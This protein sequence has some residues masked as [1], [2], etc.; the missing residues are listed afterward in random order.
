[1]HEIYSLRL[2]HFSPNVCY[3]KQKQLSN[4]PS[5]KDNKVKGPSVLLLSK[6]VF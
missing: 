1:M 5:E 3:T 2:L 4:K 6:F